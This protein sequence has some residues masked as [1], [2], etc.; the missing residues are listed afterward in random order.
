M[1]GGEFTREAG[2]P[3]VLGA[4]PPFLPKRGGGPLLEITNEAKIV[5]TWISSFLNHPGFRLPPE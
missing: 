3:S 2:D 5:Q 1:F 4:R